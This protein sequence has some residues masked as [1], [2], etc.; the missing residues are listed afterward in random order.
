VRKSTDERKEFHMAGKPSYVAFIDDEG[1]VM[2]AVDLSGKPLD[3]E[4]GSLAKTI[5]GATLQS[6]VTASTTQVAKTAYKT[7]RCVWRINPA[8]G[9]LECV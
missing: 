6:D 3:V 5:V 2:G 4:D 8:T 7:A 1:T 9:K